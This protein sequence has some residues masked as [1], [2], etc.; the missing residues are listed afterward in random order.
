LDADGFDDSPE[1]LNKRTKFW[2]LVSAA[3]ILVLLNPLSN[4]LG[5][6]SAILGQSGFSIDV[7]VMDKYSGRETIR[8]PGAWRYV[9]GL[10]TTPAFISLMV[11]ITLFTSALIAEIVRGSI[12]A[13]PRGQVEAAISLGLSPFQRMR[14]IILP[15]ALRSMIPLMTNQYLNIWKN[16]SLALVVGYSDFFSVMWTIINKEGQAVPVFLIIILTYQTGSLLISAIMNSYNRK[17]MSV[18]I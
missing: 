17:V 15:Q 4:L 7:P 3:L 18:K 12:Q 1:G 8:P 13:L 5:E 9:G 11:G 10:Q 2:V 14:L 16:S 6:F